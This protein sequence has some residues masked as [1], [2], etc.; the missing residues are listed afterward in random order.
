MV[1]LGLGEDSLLQNRVGEDVEEVWDEEHS[2]GRPG[3]G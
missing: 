2:E 1:G 3:G